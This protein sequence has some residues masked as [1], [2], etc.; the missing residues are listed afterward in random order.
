MKQGRTWIGLEEPPNL[1]SYSLNPNR[2]GSTERNE[3]EPSH[4]DEGTARKAGSC[5][6]RLLDEVDTPDL[7]RSW[8]FS[9]KIFDLFGQS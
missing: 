6:E 5:E 3:L 4:G 8:N 2:H 1:Q 7:G 9:K